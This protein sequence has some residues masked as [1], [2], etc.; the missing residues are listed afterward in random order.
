MAAVLLT[1]L[2]LGSIQRFLDPFCE[3]SG[4]GLEVRPDLVLSHG[5]RPLD[6]SRRAASPPLSACLSVRLSVFSVF[7]SNPPGC[8][9]RFEAM[10]VGQ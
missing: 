2:L 7:L 9:L 5:P 3:E 6:L 4:S 8:W 10:E 1:H